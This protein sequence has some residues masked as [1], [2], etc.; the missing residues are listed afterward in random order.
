MRV[1]A[2]ECC[3]DPVLPACLPWLWSAG[4]FLAGVA[5][6]TMHET[7]LVWQKQ[8]KRIAYWLARFFF[9][10]T[11]ARRCLSMVGGVGYWLG[12]CG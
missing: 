12:R 4:T 3:V 10:G 5:F 2:R 1:C 6:S 11:C 8:V 7:Y 9:A